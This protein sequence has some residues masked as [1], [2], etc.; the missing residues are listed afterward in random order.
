MTYEA[1]AQVLEGVRQQLGQQQI[2]IGAVGIGGPGGPGIVGIAQG[3]APGSTNI[4]FMAS[5]DGTQSSN[6]SQVLQNLIS[7]LRSPTPDKSKISV[8]WRVVRG[9]VGLFCPDYLAKLDAILG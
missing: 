6:Q 2:N 9:V 7:E 1:A 4:G 3:G 5:A 8:L